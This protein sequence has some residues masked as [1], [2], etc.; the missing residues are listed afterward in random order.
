MYNQE[1][2]QFIEDYDEQIK[3][4]NQAEEEIDDYKNQFYNRTNQLIDYVD[5]FYHGKPDINIRPDYQAFEQNLRE[6]NLDM[7]RERNQLE[8]NRIELQQEFSRKLDEYFS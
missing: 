7:N 2:F 3:M 5:S 1:K 4:I 6:F 8:E